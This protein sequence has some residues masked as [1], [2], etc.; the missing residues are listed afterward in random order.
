[1]TGYLTLIVGLLAVIGSVW[2]SVWL[3]RRH[4]FVPG[5]SDAG[6]G[7]RRGAKMLGL[8]DVR[9][10]QLFQAR[11]LTAW[12][13]V[14]EFRI[15][16][17]LWEQVQTP[18]YRVTIGFPQP[19]RRGIRISRD[20]NGGLMQRVLDADAEKNSTNEDILVQ[21]KQNIGELRSFLQDD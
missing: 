8:D 20:A 9:E 12:G 7:L 10:S 2:V 18:F 15:N 11:V 14:N 6:D 19:L 17:E 16:C 1:M 4:Q 21:S 13:E 3:A 5:T